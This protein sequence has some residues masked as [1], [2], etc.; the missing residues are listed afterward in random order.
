MP[1]A[2]T[3]P[4]RR[5]SV[6]LAGP[7]SDR[8]RSCVDF[9]IS[10]GATGDQPS[11]PLWKGGDLSEKSDD[12]CSYVS[13]SSPTYQGV[14]ASANA[15]S[16][17]YEVGVPKA[18]QDCNTGKKA[19]SYPLEMVSAPS[20]FPDTYTS[21]KAS[22]GKSAAKP[23]QTKPKKTAIKASS[24]SN[25]AQSNSSTSSTK[26]CS[27]LRKRRHS[28]RSAARFQGRSVSH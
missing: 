28:R 8:P 5:A 17:A 22:G 14:C 2:R 15:C 13:V 23:K 1:R 12:A 9:T 21:Y 11:C 6:P 20:G 27:S 10:G 16:G 26:K 18:I 3:R 19:T 4:S 25:K 24:G 7:G